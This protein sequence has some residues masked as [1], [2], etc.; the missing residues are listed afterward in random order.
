M[1]W[2]V[3]RVGCVNFW[4]STFIV[5]LSSFVLIIAAIKAT[6]RASLQKQ[7]KGIPGEDQGFLMEGLVDSNRPPNLFVYL[8]GTALRF[9]PKYCSLVR[10]NWNMQTFAY[11]LSS[12]L[13]RQ[14]FFHTSLLAKSENA[15]IRFAILATNF[16]QTSLLLTLTFF[17]TCTFLLSVLKRRLIG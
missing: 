14:L 15:V 13:M 2:R 12:N 5:S 9:P 17:L 6:L 16:L 8:F 3:W 10:T 4:W 1:H 11:L 7:S